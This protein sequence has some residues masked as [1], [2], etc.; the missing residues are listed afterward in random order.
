MPTLQRLSLLSA[1][2]MTSSC[3]SQ[4][5]SVPLTPIHATSAPASEACTAFPRLSF[6]RLHDT[7]ETIKGIKAYDAARDALCGVGK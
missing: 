3:A 4:T 7:P 1:L 5:P 6:S 2:V